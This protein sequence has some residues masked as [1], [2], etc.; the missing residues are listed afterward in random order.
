MTLPRKTCC[1]AAGAFIVFG[2]AYLSAQNVD[3]P[4]YNGGIDGDHYS[5]LTQ[6]DRS[7]VAK[8]AQAWVFDTGEKG[9]IQDNPLVIGRTLYAYTPSQKIVALDAATGELKW[10][11]DSGIKG[12]QPARGMTWWTDGKERRLLAGVMNFLYC[13][14]PDTG[15]PISSFGESGRVDLRKDLRGNFEEQSIALTSPGVI[16]VP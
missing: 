4:A 9:G 1:A 15:K 2:A 8:L 13:L 14:D 11:F 16:Y 6:I 5:K 10:K 7:N 12:Q 3:W